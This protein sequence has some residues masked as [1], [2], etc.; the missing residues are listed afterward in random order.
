M[1]WIARL[2]GVSSAG[3]VS[4]EPVAF[5]FGTGKSEL[6]RIRLTQPRNAQCSFLDIS[7]IALKIRTCF[8]AHGMIITGG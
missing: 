8:T 5:L 2:S 6:G 3:A 4:E 1:F 7:I